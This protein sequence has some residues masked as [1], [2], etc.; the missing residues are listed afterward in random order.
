MSVELRT[1][2]L[3]LRT[4]RPEDADGVAEYLTDAEAMRFL[5]GSIVPREAIPAVIER[6]L[7]GWEVDGFGRLVVERRSDG[8]LL[9]R[10]GP[11][12]FDARTWRNATLAD[13]GEHAQ[14]E[15]GWALLRAHW[16]CGYA[17]EAALAARDW[18]RGL[19]GGRLVS[20]IHPENERSRRVAERLG[21]A[22]GE[23]VT[24]FDDSLAVAW[25]HA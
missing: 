4:P 12:V 10:V 8:R 7:A 13:A 18:A 6:W 24:M 21:A 25:A 23:T 11:T 20:L 22:P 5:G 3:R 9:G 17:T 14:L 1:E 2:R 19:T 15:L 16:G